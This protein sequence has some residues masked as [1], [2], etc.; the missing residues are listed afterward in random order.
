AERDIAAEERRDP[1]DRGAQSAARCRAARPD[2]AAK[3]EAWE[4]IVRDERPRIAMAAATGFWQPGQEALT[5]PYVERFFAD[6]PA[7]VAGRYQLF[8]RMLVRHAFPRY[9]TRSLQ[10]AGDLLARDGLDP[11]LRREIGDAADE[12]KYFQDLVE[13]GGHR[14]TRW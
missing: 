7:M 12:Q 3:A 11:V 2:A 8:A 9:S 1:S 14:S 13:A 10:L 6:A 5:D 4:R